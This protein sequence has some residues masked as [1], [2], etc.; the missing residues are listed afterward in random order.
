[1]HTLYAHTHTHTHTHTN[2]HT[3]TFTNKSISL[4]HVVFLAWNRTPANDRL[5]RMAVLA[6]VAA[7]TYTFPSTV[8][9]GCTRA[10][11][12]STLLASTSMVLPKMSGLT[13]M[14]AC[15]CK[16]GKVGS[17]AVVP[18]PPPPPSLDTDHR[19]HIADCR[20]QTTDHRPQIAEHR[21]QTTNTARKSPRN[22]P[23]S[24]RNTSRNHATKG[25][26]GPRRGFF[27]QGS[28][29]R[30]GGGFLGQKR[31]FLA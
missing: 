13:S 12:G 23:S 5:R 31:G 15:K 4:Y 22:T 6:H 19:Q 10:A 20:S 27:W 29:A 18:P 9:M 28:Y 21:P 8:M 16:S 30:K 3:H 17:V 11:F 1:M 26:P 25:V 2:T 14:S 24:A 7:S